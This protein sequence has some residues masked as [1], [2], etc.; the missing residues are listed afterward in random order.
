MFK[1][2]LLLIGLAAAPA[3]FAGAASAQ[4]LT[5]Y[6]GRGESFVAP[7]IEMFEKESGKDVEV[8]YGGT[9]EL[10]TL[11]KEEGA[12]TPADLFWAQDGGALGAT[13]D[14]FEVLPAE[15]SAAE[16]PQFKNADNKWVGTSARARVL[17]Y[18]TERAPKDQLPDSVLKL[19]E[20]AWKGKVGWA[21]A[22]GSFQAFVTALRVK[23]GEE[24]AKA[25]VDGMVA[26][27]AKTY[28]NNVS[29][30]QAIA[31]G[32]IDVA[33]VNNYYLNRFTQRDAK[34]P[35]AMTFFKNGDI[36]NLLNV[37]GVG[38]LKTSD[39]KETAQDFAE[40]LLTPAV[41]Q[42]F[43]SAG[44]EYPV[45]AGVIPNPSL[46][47]VADIKAAA[48]EVPLDQLSDLEGTLNLLRSAN[49]L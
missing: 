48:P 23:E 28:P 42:Y 27:G 17:V 21:P 5:I 3:L 14:L 12:N 31:D 41:Q 43:T 22:N 49:L 32:E 10:A 38:V 6:S 46:A 34:F 36:G 35:V 2:P 13:A 30:V 45:I 8:R 11:L 25:W 29:L 37:A 16:N 47:P 19:T 44:N 33:L 7:V 20:P 1:R 40:F 24:A 4:D 39:A 15:L 9:A 26:N 18:S